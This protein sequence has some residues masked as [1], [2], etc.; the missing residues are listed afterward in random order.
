MQSS[1]SFWMLWDAGW[2]PQ[3][4]Q[5]RRSQNS[6]TPTAQVQSGASQPSTSA[7]TQE[8]RRECGEKGKHELCKH[9]VLLGGLPGYP[10]PLG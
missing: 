4:L 7:E 3:Q 9:S 10:E 8:N 1:A 5:N 2:A 6:A